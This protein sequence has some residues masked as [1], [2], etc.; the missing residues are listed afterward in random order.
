M[1][2]IYFSKQVGIRTG[3][4]CKSFLFTF[5]SV[6]SCLADD[7]IVGISYEYEQEIAAIL[8]LVETIEEILE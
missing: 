5:I 7:G 1:F 3:I 2:G 6:M 8:S 4:G